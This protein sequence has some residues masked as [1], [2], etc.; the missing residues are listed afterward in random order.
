[1][2]FQPPRT[3]LHAVDGVPL[4]RMTFRNPR[5]AFRRTRMAIPGERETLP[6]ADSAAER[7]PVARTASR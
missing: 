3:I 4:I 6:S 7:N 1:M 5:I 2:A